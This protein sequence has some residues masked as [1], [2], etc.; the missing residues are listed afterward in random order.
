MTQKEESLK[1]SG[2]STSIFS[3]DEHARFRD[4][5]FLDRVF[6][7]Q[8]GGSVC[9][10]IDGPA[11]FRSL[12]EF[13]SCGRRDVHHSHRHSIFFQNVWYPTTLSST[14]TIPS[15]M[16]AVD[17]REVDYQMVGRVIAR[18]T[19]GQYFTEGKNPGFFDLFTTNLF[20]HLPPMSE[21]I[22]ELVYTINPLLAERES[23]TSI[24]SVYSLRIQ[25]LIKEILNNPRRRA[26]KL[27]AEENG[28]P[29]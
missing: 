1:K 24:H 6:G 16:P 5:R 3:T 26:F 28:L 8:I 23:L 4:P 2:T 17:S 9:L 14:S 21:G 27:L 18:T 7:H 20:S 10:A 25:E 13:T 19:H 15:T 22:V 12:V 11:Q 29:S